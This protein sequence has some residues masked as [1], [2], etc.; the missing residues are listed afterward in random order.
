M[1]Q[2]MATQV[3]EE[4]E[5]EIDA[6]PEYSSTP[7]PPPPAV[8]GKL[9]PLLPGLE[10]YTLRNDV[11]VVGRSAQADISI[12]DP[13][14]S[15]KHCEIRRDKRSGDV[16]I[17]DRS[18]NGTWVNEVKLKKNVA[19]LLSH[20]DQVVLAV[21]PASK[22]APVA[23]FFFQQPTEPG[24]A[25]AASNPID[26][27]Y[28]LGAVIGRGACGYVRRAQERTTGK[29][30]AIKVIDK[31]R[32]EGERERQSEMI[33]REATLL[34]KC[35]HPN[36]TRCFDVIDT[37]R[38]VYIVMEF[39]GGGELLTKLQRDGAFSESDAK[40]VAHKI[41]DAVNYL[42]NTLVRR[43]AAGARLSRAR[44]R[45]ALRRAS[46]RA[47]PLRESSLRAVRPPI[48]LSLAHLVPPPPSSPGNCP[49]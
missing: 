37:D 44:L 25:S 43:R 31:K 13:K 12:T 8:W 18:V 19:Q 36:I 2:M 26:Q 9:L 48:A 38:S 29:L 5:D 41:L 4:E 16:F 22:V 47:P 7:P 45:T 1:S 10:L 14:I 30:V 21:G 3:C 24:S 6:A 15:S 11:I 32:R 28:V 20:S 42:H 39:V 49:P 33:R 46:L 27:Q 35:N 34:Q 40:V 23:N 17:T